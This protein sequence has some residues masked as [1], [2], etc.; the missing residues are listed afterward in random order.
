MVVGS[1]LLAC[2]ASSLKPT[3][4]EDAT[5]PLTDSFH[6]A[7]ERV[8]AGKCS[9]TKNKSTGVVPSSR[10]E[11]SKLLTSGFCA[12]RLKASVEASNLRRVSPPSPGHFESHL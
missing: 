6:P 8:G 7:D 9:R 4:K 11:R 1:V 12:R 5:A 10:S 2:A 3:S